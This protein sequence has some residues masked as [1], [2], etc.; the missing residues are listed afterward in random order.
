MARRIE[1]E[2]ATGPTPFRGRVFQWG[3]RQAHRKSCVPPGCGCGGCF[4]ILAILALSV[5]YFVVRGCTNWFQSAGPTTSVIQR[6]TT[7]LGEFTVSP[8][9][10]VGTR[11]LDAETEDTV[12]TSW[13]GV[14]IG[15]TVTRVRA[16]ENR[17]QYIVDLQDLDP[18]RCVVGNGGRELVFRFPS[19]IVDADMVDVQSDPSKYAFFVDNDWIHHF[20]VGDDRIDEGRRAMRNAVVH[21]ASQPS[22]RSEARAAAIP[23]LESLIRGL[24]PAGSGVDEVVVVFDEQ[25]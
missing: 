6:I 16:L 7:R 9:F 25:R 3:T 17:V 13:F 24:L 21:A 22:A 8:R 18:A 1:A 5:P 14:K 15:Q 11:L 20:I 23:V 2:N 12:T 10:V 4:V 19:P